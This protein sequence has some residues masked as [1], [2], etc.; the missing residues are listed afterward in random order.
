MNRRLLV[1]VTAPALLLG[2]LLFG[3]CL[4]AVWYTN[5]L[6]SSLARVISQNVAGL[7]AA[8]ELEIRL[9]QLRSHTFL[10]LIE[11]TPQRL[12]PIEQDHQRFE[13]ALAEAR[14]SALGPA[15]QTCVRDIEAGYRRYRDELTQLRAA[16]LSDGPR[17]DFG[18]L[19]DRHPIRYVTEPCHEL[20][21]LNKEEMARTALES[22]RTIRR[23]NLIVLLLGVGGPAGGLVLGYRV[24]RRL[25]KSI[26]R[27]SVRVQ[28]MAQRLDQK[29]ASVSL[30]VDGDI[31]HLDRQMQDVVGRVEEVTERLQRQQRQML[32]AEQLAAVGQLAASVAHEIR[33][34][35]TS[36]KLLLEAALRPANAKPLTAEDLHILHEEAGRMECTVQAFLNFARLPTPRREC[37][38]LGQIIAQAVELIRPRAQQQGVA[39]AVRSQAALAWVDR[40]QLGTVLVNLLLNALD[41]MPAGGRLEVLLEPRAGGFEIAV[42]DT[43]PGLPTE[44]AD[45]L[46]TPFLTTKPTGTGLGLSI[47]R[48]IVEEHEGQ[49]TARNRAEGGACFTISLPAGAAPT[50][51]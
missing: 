41:A 46:F 48:R 43:G 44:V 51:R 36:I 39:V 23:A 47:S 24:S 17:T 3:A 29:V 16:V 4:V 37:C 8:Q 22:N 2:G 34:P 38:D 27:L 28:D 35:L 50:E 11:P 13:E 20:L 15:E 42:A 26:Y 9:R 33:N 25:G 18:R 45:R 1:E 10:Y 40:G 14:A 6:E 21:R 7:E 12:E 5:Y 19:S 30:H 49:L 32:R 31:E